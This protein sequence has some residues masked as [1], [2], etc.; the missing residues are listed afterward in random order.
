MEE[1]SAILRDQSSDIKSTNSKETNK[2][3]LRRKLRSGRYKL[4]AMLATGLFACM[5]V[6]LAG[7]LVKGTQHILSQLNIDLGRY[8][9]YMKKVMNLTQDEKIE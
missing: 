8:N 9:I 1:F 6:I 7:I 5:S 4:I 2:N 3:V